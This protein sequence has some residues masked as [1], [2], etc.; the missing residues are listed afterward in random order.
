MGGNG[1]PEAYLL[2]F[3]TKN[4]TPRTLGHAIIAIQR[5]TPLWWVTATAP[6]L[7]A[8]QRIKGN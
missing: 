1:L 5:V 3:D 4:P 2:G 6:R 8:P 7:R